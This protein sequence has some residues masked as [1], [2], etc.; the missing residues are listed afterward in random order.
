MFFSL[1][2]GV[3]VQGVNARLLGKTGRKGRAGEAGRGWDTRGPS[4]HPPSPGEPGRRGRDAKSSKQNTR[5]PLSTFDGFTDN[6]QEE[7]GFPRKRRR[8][9]KSLHLSH[10][11]KD[12]LF[13]GH[14]TGRNGGKRGSS[15]NCWVGLSPVTGLSIQSPPQLPVRLLHF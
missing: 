10:F 1:Q 3:F 4:R 12:K 8:K 7:P 5:S 14:K 13:R 6:S 11:S 15:V 2:C 9:G